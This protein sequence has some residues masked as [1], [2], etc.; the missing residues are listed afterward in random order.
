MK[1]VNKVRRWLFLAIATI[2]TYQGVHFII[3]LNPEAPQLQ[4]IIVG[5]IFVGVPAFLIAWVA[6]PPYTCEEC[7][8]HDAMEPL[9]SDE[10]LAFITGLPLERS[11]GRKECRDCMKR[12]YRPW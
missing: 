10:E 8:S 9:I 5:L 2:I 4:Q 3:S 11:P 7:G 1:R 12:Q 6:T